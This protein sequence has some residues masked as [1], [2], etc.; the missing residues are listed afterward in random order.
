VHNISVRERLSVMP[1]TFCS[2]STSGA[3][4]STA[5]K[6]PLIV[7][8]RSSGSCRLRLLLPKFDC[9]GICGEDEVRNECEDAATERDDTSPIMMRM[10]NNATASSI[11]LPLVDDMVVDITG[12]EVGGGSMLWNELVRIGSVDEK[13]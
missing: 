8:V 7:E 11:L 10:V 12:L 13:Q 4:I 9:A 6:S 3:W 2:S 5:D 1:R